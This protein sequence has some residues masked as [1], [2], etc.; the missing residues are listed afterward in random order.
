MTDLLPSP[1]R[2][3]LIARTELRRRW[4][5]LLGG[6][7]LQLVAFAFVAL[8]AL[9]FGGGAVFGAYFL[10]AAVRSGELAG[11][12]GLARYAFAAL[13]AGV[14]GL[15]A[16][17]TVSRGGRI[18]RSDGLLTTVPH[19]DVLGGLVLSEYAAF[20]VAVAV[21]GL[22]IAASFA[23]GAA[24][25]ATALLGA[26]ALWAGV[27]TAFVA[28]FLL[29][30]VLKGVLV[31][32]EF[33][34][35]YRLAL[36]ALAFAAY[37]GLIL[38]GSFE[39]VVGPVVALF[40]ASP[41]AWYADLALLAVAP[42]A[43]AVRAAAVAA[44]TIPAVLVLIAAAVRAA[45]WFWYADPARATARTASH[46][47]AESGWFDRTVG[48]QVAWIARTSWLRARRAPIKLVYVAYPL[49]GLVG[50]LTNTVQSGEVGAFLPVVLAFYGAAATG[51]LFTLNPLGDEGAVLPVT[52]TSTV[53]G[54]RFV[55]GR[56]LA[57][58]A[59]G[60]PATVLVALAVGA[61][62]PLPPSR[63]ALVAVVAAVLGVASTGIAAGVGALFPRFSAAKVTR[64]R[65]AVVP[66]LVAFGVYSIL[67][68]L[69][70]LPGLVAAV[71]LV[72][73]TA[74]DLAGTSATA[75]VA[76][77]SGLT[78]LIAAIGG[79]VGARYAAG[80]FDRFTL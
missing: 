37:M 3:A 61:L 74:A 10:G 68:G 77:G 13:W 8:F 38:T 16:F 49:F 36:G 20:I 32:S 17:R 47:S 80:A 64:S 34:A 24:S 79:F 76:V 67:L 45:E 63:V 75:V 44:A 5:A 53:D 72:A 42:G 1:S 59:V 12:L 62:S 6:N 22:L 55:R 65:E 60:T 11:Y 4:R 41:A 66:S 26:V 54:R 2:S 78:L 57:G 21:A 18:D 56:M 50:E 35:R 69:V 23:L 27:T 25:P 52:I 7:P 14:F 28:G 43:S 40:R 48:G 51:A 9:I 15:Y 31:R 30:L 58:V 71:P 73:E 33:V 46:A 39:T 70:A 29:A 19:R